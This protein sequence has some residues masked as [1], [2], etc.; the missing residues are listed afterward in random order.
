MLA[1]HKTSLEEDLPFEYSTP[2]SVRYLIDN[3]QTLV[4]SDVGPKGAC[5][6]C[7]VHVTMQ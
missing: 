7:M 1:V 6:F 4:F 5:R 3:L 2:P